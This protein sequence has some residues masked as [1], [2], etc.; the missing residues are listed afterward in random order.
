MY[1]LIILTEKMSKGT[2]ITFTELNRPVPYSVKIKRVT[3]QNVEKLNNNSTPPTLS[4]IL[5]RIKKHY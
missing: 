3:E 1:V 5:F 2:K 4:F